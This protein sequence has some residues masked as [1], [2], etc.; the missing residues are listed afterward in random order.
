[1]FSRHP[2]APE[3]RSSPPRHGF[4]PGRF[5]WVIR[6]LDNRKSQMAP[7][8][9]QLCR[10]RLSRPNSSAKQRTGR[11]QVS[12]G[13]TV[14][15]AWPGR[16][17]PP[18]NTKRDYPKVRQTSATSAAHAEEGPTVAEMGCLTE[19]FAFGV[20]WL[21]WYAVLHASAVGLCSWFI[22]PTAGWC[23][24]ADFGYRG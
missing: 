7:V 5:S 13:V 17:V 2:A 11:L 6:A 24:E 3:S 8:A 23:R 18:A 9:Q 10:C 15:P 4:Q 19:I 16:A 1:M 21:H 12:A 20:H 22:R 14:P